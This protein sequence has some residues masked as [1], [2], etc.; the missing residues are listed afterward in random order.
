MKPLRL[1]WVSLWVCLVTGLAG[2]A[3][4]QS[5]ST[6]ARAGDT[7]ALALGRQLD[8]KRANLTITITPASGAPVVYAPNDARVR[9]VVNLYPDPVSLA[10]VGTQTDQ[11]LGVNASSSTGSLIETFVTPDSDWWQTTLLLDIPS[12]LA[13]GAA[14]IS[15]SDAGGAVI[16]PIAL[17]I[18]PGTG[19]ANNFTIY[20]TW[21]ST[22]PLLSNFPYLIK[23]ME[24]AER[25]TVGF[26]GDTIPHSMQLDFSRIAGVGKP[27]VANP[28]G[29]IKNVI[30]SDDGSVMRVM[31]T[32]TGGAPLN[33]LLDFKF[34]IAGGITGLTLTSLKAY[35]IN[36]TLMSGINALVQ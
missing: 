26:S 35:D 28:R 34:Y 11:D 27:W 14:S 6:A 16:K 25:Y 1:H 18:L 12:P 5:F 29:D 3:G 24:R 36:G 22:M 10:V 19:P 15:I 23:S 8:L 30:W 13:A 9:G 7:V 20:N 17:D 2:C 31:L 33:R 32:P 21:G 4:T